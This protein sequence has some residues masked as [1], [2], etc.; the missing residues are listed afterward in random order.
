MQLRGATVA[1]TGATGFLGRYLVDTLRARGAHVI[2][3]VRNPE[4]VPALRA[5]GVELRRADLADRTRLAE[6]FR[7]AQALVSNAALFSL[8]NRGW[9][10]HQQANVH[11]T[12][13]VFDA[14]ADAGVPRV[15]RGT[16]AAGAGAAHAHLRHAA[17]AGG[18]RVAEPPVRGRVVR[19]VR[20]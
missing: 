5:R 8:Q 2:G 11:G 15:G 19:Y 14:A 18:A 9:D 13:N 6:G 16:H 1:V 3:V 4:R 17:G 20:A 7:D 10:E 12:T